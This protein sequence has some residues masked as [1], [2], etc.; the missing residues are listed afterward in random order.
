MNSEPRSQCH[1]PS[2]LSEA[3]LGAGPVGASA[4]TTSR[5]G[6]GL[7][8]M[9]TREF[10]RS[11]QAVRPAFFPES[12]RT[13]PPFGGQPHSTARALPAESREG[14]CAAGAGGAR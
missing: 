1:G 13:G 10:M 11:P 4:S 7:R 8:V 14:A 12:E 9:V 2:Q 5:S 3:R 6:L